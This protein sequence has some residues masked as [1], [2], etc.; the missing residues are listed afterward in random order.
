MYRSKKK[1]YSD[2]VNDKLISLIE[3]T[4]YKDDKINYFNY[5]IN[6]SCNTHTIYGSTKVQNEKVFIQKVNPSNMSNTRRRILVNMKKINF[7]LIN[8]IN[9]DNII[10]K[11]NIGG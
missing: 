5:A 11:I 1:I 9:I 3:Y 10:Q 4:Y 2:N 8:D 7:Y 6:I